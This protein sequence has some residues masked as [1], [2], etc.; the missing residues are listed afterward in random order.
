MKKNKKIEY[1]M[2]KLGKAIR[3]KEEEEVRGE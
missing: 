3:K 1:W 2:S